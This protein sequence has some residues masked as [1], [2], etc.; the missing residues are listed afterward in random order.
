MKTK[1]ARNLTGVALLLAS[2]PLY[3]DTISATLELGDSVEWSSASIWELDGASAGRVPT[4]GDNVAISAPMGDGS[5]FATVTSGNLNESA[6]WGPSGSLTLDGAVKL[7]FSA[8]DMSAWGNIYLKQGSVLEVNASYW[9]NFRLVTADSQNVNFEVNKGASFIL[10]GTSFSANG[11][12]NLTTNSV[13]NIDVK[14][15]VTIHNNGIDGRT[16]TGAIRLADAK[17]SITNLNIYGSANIQTLAAY[18]PD[19]PEYDAREL[20]FGNNQNPC[21]ANVTFFMQDIRLDSIK[22]QADETVALLNV[23]KLVYK[24]GCTVSLVVDFSDFSIDGGEFSVGET[25]DFALISA[26][27]FGSTLDKLTYTNADK[28]G[29]NWEIDSE[30]WKKIEDGTL[31]VSLSYVPEPSAY[32]AVFGLLALA[33]AACK[34]RR[35]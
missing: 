8:A 4:A 6:K 18:N 21:Y 23:S 28:L 3:A 29:A 17:D 32:A 5:Q 13:V 27:D 9:S 2:I 15:N 31:Y 30:N 11:T 12:H 10:N 26:T 14:G 20:Y 35:A 1:K 24:S 33:L 16:D 19:R 25:Y 7:V 22:G 34:R